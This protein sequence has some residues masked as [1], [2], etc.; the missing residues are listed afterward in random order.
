[1]NI[2]EVF[3]KYPESEPNYNG[4]NYLTLVDVNGNISYA[5][6]YFN[7]DAEFEPKCGKVVAFA[8]KQPIIV[9]NSL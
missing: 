5:I 3:K 9:L 1:M 7:N 8:D 2:S 4:T 6:T